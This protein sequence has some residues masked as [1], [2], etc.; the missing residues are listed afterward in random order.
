[1]PTVGSDLKGLSKLGRTSKP[2]RELET[3][4]N[5]CPNLVVHCECTEFTCFCPLTNQPDF[6]NIRIAYKA[7]ALCVE[8]KSLKLYLET[9]RNTGVFHEHLA[10]DIAN[11]FMEAL[12]PEF[13]RVEV[14]F[15][16]RGGIAISATCTLPEKSND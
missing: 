9:F 8:S 12:D 4:P 5:R 14:N 11:D 6:A 1:M 10:Y 7:K 15:N 13:V 2:E 16:V 3:F